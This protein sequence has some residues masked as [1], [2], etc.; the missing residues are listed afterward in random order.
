MINFSREFPADFLIFMLY[1][2]VIVVFFR[3]LLELNLT[4]LV[5]VLILLVAAIVLRSNF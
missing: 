3:E 5:P 2:L 1:I 4:I